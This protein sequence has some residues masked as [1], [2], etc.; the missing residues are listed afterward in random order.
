MSEKKICPTCGTAYDVD[1]SRDFIFCNYCG[2]KIMFKEPQPEVQPEPQMQI[3]PEP[4][5]QQPQPQMQAQQP[6]PQ[7]QAPYNPYPQAAAAQP[8][9]AANNVPNLHIQYAAINP[10]VGMVVHFTATNQMNYYFAG[11]QYS[12]HLPVGMHQ[13]VLKIGK[14][15]YNRTIFIREDNAPVTIYASWDGRA[16][17]IIDQP[18]Y[19]PVVPMQPGAPVAYYAAPGQ[20]YGAP[21]A[22]PVQMVA[23]KTCP[24]CGKGLDADA[25]FCT[26]CG[27]KL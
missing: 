10:T 27:T 12:Y 11:Q 13:L 5:V 1:E 7:P 4:Q 17:I 22:A 20:M 23:P 18:P 15:S 21:M 16:H 2:T 14:I 6:Q 24:R 19:I 25:E 26:K 8:A 3:Q 9:P